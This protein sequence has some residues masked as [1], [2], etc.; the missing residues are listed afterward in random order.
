MF[1]CNEVKDNMVQS[2]TSIPKELWIQCMGHFWRKIQEKSAMSHP[3]LAIELK[4][5]LSA[6]NEDQP[7]RS[8]KW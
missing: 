7:L 1:T 4:M 8:I 2:L 6:M 3:K 5:C